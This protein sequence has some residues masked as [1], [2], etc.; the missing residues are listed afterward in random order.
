MK[1]FLKG[2]GWICIG[3]AVLGGPQV[4]VQQNFAWPSLVAELFWVVLAWICFAK[5]KKG[6]VTNEKNEA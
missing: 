6:K 4:M 1:T 2:L 3:I 5:S